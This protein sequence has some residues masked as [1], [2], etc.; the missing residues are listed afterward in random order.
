VVLE[1]PAGELLD[2]LG[3]ALGQVDHPLLD[4]QWQ[5]QLNMSAIRHATLARGLGTRLCRS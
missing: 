2:L 5:P 3:L 4:G 1:V